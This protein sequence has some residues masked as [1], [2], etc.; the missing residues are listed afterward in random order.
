VATIRDVATTAGVSVKTV[1]RVLN[2]FRNVSP[3]TKTRVLAAINALDYCPNANARNLALSFTKTIALCVTYNSNYVFSNSYFSEVF[4]GINEICNQNGYSLILQARPDCDYLE[5]ARGGRVDGM[6][7]MCVRLEEEHLQKL[8]GSGFPFVLIGKDPAD[9]RIP[10]VEVDDELGAYIATKHLLQLGHLTIGYL[11]GPRQ[12]VSSDKRL[13]G[14]KKALSEYGLA[15]DPEFI[16]SMPQPDVQNGYQ[17]MHR[18]LTN[19]RLPSALIVFND[20]MATGALDALQEKKIK[21]PQEFAIVGFDDII[22]APHTNPPLTTV[23][24]PSFDKGALATRLLLKLIHGEPVDNHQIL[25]KPELIVRK[26]C[27]SGHSWD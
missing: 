14:F 10:W 18:L 11:G 2:N 19:L 7:L 15:P 16:V 8:I 5:L 23:R 24:Q 26:S 22:T 12:Y 13:N 20:L 17:A 3:D 1:S 25:L 27:G 21:V 6:L 9:R 4:R